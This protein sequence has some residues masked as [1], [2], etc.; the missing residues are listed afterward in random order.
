MKQAKRKP[1]KRAQLFELVPLILFFAAYQLYNLKIATM[2]LMATSSLSLAI[3]YFKLRYVSV[4][5]VIGTVMI[6]LF[7]AL[8]VLLNDETFIKLRPTI[9][10]TL[11]G[12]TLLIGVYGFKRGLL[13]DI[14]HMAFSLTD[15]GWR[16][17]SKRFGFFFLFL[18]GMNELVWR[19]QVTDVWVDYK[20]FG[21]MGLMFLFMLS[22]IRLI[23]QHREKE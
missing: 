12:C 22:Q 3:A 11:F 10:N 16:I 6:V 19:T 20:L 8:T 21:T 4:P 9:V 7:G 23:E 1:P 15:T 17:F 13:G 18:A 2:V 14:F 5:L